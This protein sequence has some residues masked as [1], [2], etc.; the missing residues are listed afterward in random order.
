M[1]Q[2]RGNRRGGEGG[3]GGGGGSQRGRVYLL[4]NGKPTPAKVK[5]GLSDGSRTE[6]EGPVEPGAEVVIG[7][8]G[9]T[10]AAP[11]AARPF[12]MQPGAAG[13][14]RRGM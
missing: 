8:D 12:G 3:D 7:M 9:G 1:R 6:I 5:V 13:G 14:R 2:G 10:S 4:V 11:G